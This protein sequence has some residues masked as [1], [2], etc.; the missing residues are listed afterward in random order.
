MIILKKV[1]NDAGNVI[2]KA[3]AAFESLEKVWNDDGMSLCS[4]LNIFNNIVLSMLLYGAES[5]KGLRE[6][7]ERKRSFQCI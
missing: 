1:E 5:W 3:G 4:K 6:I 7:E 2:G